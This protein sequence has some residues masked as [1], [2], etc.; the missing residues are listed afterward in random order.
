MV[1][2]ITQSENDFILITLNFNQPDQL[3]FDEGISGHVLFFSKFKDKDDKFLYVFYDP[4]QLPAQFN[5]QSKCELFLKD[6]LNHTALE[7][8]QAFVVDEVCVVVSKYSSNTAEFHQIMRQLE[9]HITQEIA[10]LIPAKE[11]EAYLQDLAILKKKCH[12]A[13]VFG[14]NYEPPIKLS[15]HTQGEV[16]NKVT[17]F[18]QE[19]K[20]KEKKFYSNEELLKRIVHYI[21]LLKNHHPEFSN[22]LLSIMS[23]CPTHP[24][25]QS[26][27][28]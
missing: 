24:L 21:E 13:D 1:G 15:A 14:M 22:Q 26:Y 17:A 9:G 23:G 25:H 18:I 28:C 8:K 12:F 20:S 27:T 11:N 6:Y 3:Q 16:Y 5:D 4:N 19:M 2:A 7:F 10:S